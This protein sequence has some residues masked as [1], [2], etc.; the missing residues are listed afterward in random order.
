V[1]SKMLLEGGETAPGALGL[2]AATMGN[3]VCR[4]VPS[5]GNG[6]ANL[7]S[8]R[9]LAYSDTHPHRDMF[10]KL[11]MTLALLEMT[12]REVLSWAPGAPSYCAKE[13][14]ALLHT[15]L[16]ASPSTM[17]KWI[18]SGNLNSTHGPMY[19]GPSTVRL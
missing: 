8:I 3:G 14:P 11:E 12:S 1:G 18:A 17:S 9:G 7:S 4:T 10:S 19:R 16:L 13:I 5:M 2:Q 15:H 6:T